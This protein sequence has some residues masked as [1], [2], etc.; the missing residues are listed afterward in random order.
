ML[1]KSLPRYKVPF[2][3]HIFCMALC[4]CASFLFGVLI[5][6]LFVFG[7]VSSVLF[8]LLVW[9]SFSLHLYVMACW[10]VYWSSVSTTFCGPSL[11]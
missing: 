4:H 1:P 9:S 3:L 11:R 6:V 8:V 5:A 2:L 10:T 7:F